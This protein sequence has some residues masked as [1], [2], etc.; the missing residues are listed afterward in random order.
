VIGA[1]QLGRIHA[2]LAAQTPGFQLAAV[3]DPDP[4]ARQTLADEYS[5]AALPHHSQ[6]INRVEAA[7]LATPASLHA[8]IARDLLTAGL[9]LLIEKPIATTASDASQLLHLAHDAQRILQVGHVERF[10]PAWQAIRELL[11][12]P[13]F[14]EVQRFAPHAFRAN[15]VGVVLD[16]M[17]H[18]L[19]LLIQLVDSEVV[20]VSASGTSLLEGHEDFA[21]ARLEFHNGVVA[22]L[23]ASRV[24]PA[25]VRNWQVVCRDSICSIDLHQRQA[26]IIRPADLSGK[27][28]W[29]SPVM[30]RE[31]KTWFRDHLFDTVLSRDT[32]TVD[33]AN[34][35]QLELQEFAEAIRSGRAVSVDATAGYRAV[36]LAERILESLHRRR[37]AWSTSRDAPAWRRAG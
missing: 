20:G 27:L 16:L 9:H 25:T 6:L 23:T 7:V 22:H 18:D 29:R 11:D 3:V 8:P 30:S 26:E 4:A 35:I 31:Q 5:I 17:I 13:R 10:N 1:G 14:I 2:R 15:D 32:L 21:E 28:V 34:P 12:Q 19:D 37:D 24:S 36:A 33:D